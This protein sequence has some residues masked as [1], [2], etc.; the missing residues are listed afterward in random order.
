MTL[1]HVHNSPEDDHDIKTFAEWR[2]SVFHKAPWIDGLTW[3]TLRRPQNFASMVRCFPVSKRFD[4][5]FKN[6]IRKYL[7][8]IIV[9]H[10]SF[11]G[12]FRIGVRV[13]VVGEF[14]FVKHCAIVD[15]VHGIP[16]NIETSPCSGNFN[17]V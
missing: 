3:D 12:Y 13:Y 17:T 11:H 6:G 2:S 8:G 16:R 15:V 9:R 14:D 4:S 7:L 5:D 1:F 10:R